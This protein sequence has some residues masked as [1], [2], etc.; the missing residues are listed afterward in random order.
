PEDAEPRTASVRG[1]RWPHGHG[2]GVNATAQVRSIGRGGGYTRSVE[3]PLHE[4]EVGARPPFVCRGMVGW[5]RK[6][7]CAPSWKELGWSWSRCRITA[8]ALIASC[9]SPSTVR[10]AS[11]W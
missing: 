6:R 5:T 11:I 4:P 7:W 9:G 2:T 8:L 10:A 1:A 3:E